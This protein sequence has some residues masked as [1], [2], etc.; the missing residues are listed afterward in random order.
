[1]KKL[2]LTFILLSPFG[3]LTGMEADDI[4]EKESV[5]IVC[6]DGQ[7]KI[8]SEIFETL[9]SISKTIKNMT[10]DGSSNIII[11]IPIKIRIFE[12][13]IS[14]LPN[15]PI[16]TENG[17]D[18]SESEK[19]EL[20][21]KLMNKDIETLIPLLKSA[22]YLDIS[23]LMN[24]L[25][26]KVLP[27]KFT[28]ELKQFL[29]DPEYIKKLKLPKELSEAVAIRIMDITTIPQ[30]VIFNSFGKNKKNVFVN[31][32]KCT[33][34]C[35]FFC[36][37]HKG[38]LFTISVSNDGKLFASSYSDGTVCLYKLFNTNTKF[39]KKLTDNN[40]GAISIAF[41]SDDIQLAS[42][43]RDGTVCLYKISKTDSY[44]LIKKLTDNNHGAR[45]VSFSNDGTLF[46]SGHRDG[47]VCLYKI[48]KTD[49]YKLI[50]KL[51][52]NNHEARAVS[53]SNDGTLFIS[54]H[55]DGTACLYKISKTEIQ[56]IGKVNNH[57][58]GI[59]AVSFNNNGTQFISGDYDG[60]VCLYKI[61]KIE[62]QFIEKVNNHD[63]GI[64]K[65]SFNKNGTGFVSSHKDGTV[66]LYK[67]SDTE[68]QFIKKITDENSIIVRLT[69]FNNNYVSLAPFVIDDTVYWYNLSVYD[70]DVLR[71]LEKNISLKH[72][73]LLKACFAKRISL[74][75]HP[76]LYTYF[77]QLPKLIQKSLVKNDMVELSLI[78]KLDYHNQTIVR[79]AVASTATIIILF[80]VMKEK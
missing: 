8:T 27:E 31:N 66:C 25:I 57:D 56:F 47:T 18:Y 49:S 35:I 21:E 16:H 74:K 9:K 77:K 4:V 48:S 22:D 14:H 76:H 70:L 42:G 75:K 30:N 52:D 29:N 72:A 78:Q 51:T 41:S 55:Y 80:N 60:T 64:K 73:L 61:S 33:Y 63:K 37:D 1:M 17:W 6:A 28:Q 19:K 62:I 32:H 24:L 53:F 7:L 69:F 71:F 34:K 50:K 38:T 11:P 45:A 59:E 44:K 15:H 79:I 65:V 2:I 36:N 5:T 67:P 54:G 10:E 23:I 46:A 39:I 43:H 12:K 3:I 26:E 20:I 40:S 58:R 13:I 68:T